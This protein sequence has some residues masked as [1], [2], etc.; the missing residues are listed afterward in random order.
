MIKE[1]LFQEALK[2]TAT[3]ISLIDLENYVK[4]DKDWAP[5]KIKEFLK[6][7]Q[8]QPLTET[9]TEVLNKKLIDLLDQPF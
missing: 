1:P 5:R 2:I 9:D 3:M 8:I 6:K 7:Y 4:L